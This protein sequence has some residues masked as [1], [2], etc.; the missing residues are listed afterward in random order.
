MDIGC[1]VVARI[2]PEPVSANVAVS[3]YRSRS[4]DVSARVASPGA[5]EP[6]PP[7]VQ[8]VPTPV[9]TPAIQPPSEVFAAALLA[10][11][12]PEPVPSPSEVRLRLVSSWQA[13]ASPLRLTDR[14]I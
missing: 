8:P 5:L 11:Q 9:P 1:I 10:S 2:A 14:Q 7:P 3:E 4:A 13:P 6:L 12:M